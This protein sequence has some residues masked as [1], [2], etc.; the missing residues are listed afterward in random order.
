MYLV[1]WLAACNGLGPV[2]ISSIGDVLIRYG[3][4]RVRLI[5]QYMINIEYSRIPLRLQS[6]HG[7][8]R[9]P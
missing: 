2:G 5:G 8:S 1:N 7:R 4:D 3:T 9:V 6:V